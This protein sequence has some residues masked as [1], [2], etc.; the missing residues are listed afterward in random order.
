ME[1]L[2]E[3]SIVKLQLANPEVFKFNISQLHDVIC[4]YRT[5]RINRHKQKTV[6]LKRYPVSIEDI[7]NK[8]TRY[9]RIPINCYELWTVERYL[10]NWSL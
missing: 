3:D 4:E 5:Y 6:E 8:P 2:I 9:F 1:K 10:Q 7:K